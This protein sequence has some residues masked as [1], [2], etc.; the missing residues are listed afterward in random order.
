MRNQSI[1][2]LLR[3]MK[4]SLSHLP[5]KKQ[6]EISFIVDIIK[7]VINPEMILL[8]GSYAKGAFVE[9]RYNSEGT[10]FEYIS[11]YDF[12]V[13]TKHNSEKTDVQESKI[14][15]LTEII[16]PPINLEIHDIGYVNKG[17]EW[18]EYFWTDIVKQGVVLLNNNSVSLVEPRILTTDERKQKAQR[19]FDNWYPQASEFLYGAKVYQER[20]NLKI[21]T[22]NLHQSVECLYYSVLLV[23]T[24]YKPKV[25]NLWK[26]RKKSKPFSE[27]LFFIFKAETDKN[28]KHLFELLKQGYIDA[29][30]REDFKIT[31]QELQILI[32]RVS[33]MITIVKEICISRI[34]S[35]K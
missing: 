32:E 29:R 23:F 7:Q 25:H 30:Y 33:L 22:F 8:F 4:T 14:M 19:Y 34:E 11:D 3:C 16:E 35:I 10:T 26:L 17:L 24:D 5:E 21:S 27:E 28:E 13:I 9:H 2:L 1:F 20:G 6:K 31:S 18:G 12:L 15:S